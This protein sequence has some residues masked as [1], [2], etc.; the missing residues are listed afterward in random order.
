MVKL[1][2]QF[3]LP[4]NNATVERCYGAIDDAVRDYVGQMEQ[5][6]LVEGTIA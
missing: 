3:G 6:F 2:S 5:Y 1:A 4:W